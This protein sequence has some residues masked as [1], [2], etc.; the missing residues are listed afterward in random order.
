MQAAAREGLPVKMVLTHADA[1]AASIALIFHGFSQPFLA[2][3][4]N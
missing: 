4:E 3:R 1:G 2:Q